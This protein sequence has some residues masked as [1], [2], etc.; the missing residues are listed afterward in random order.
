MKVRDISEFL[1]YFE[2][3]ADSDSH[4]NKFGLKNGW[5]SGQIFFGMLSSL[6]DALGPK[7][8]LIFH[9]FL[10]LGLLPEKFQ[11]YKSDLDLFCGGFVQKMNEVKRSQI[12]YHPVSHLPQSVPGWVD[13]RGDITMLCAAIQ[14][15]S[16]ISFVKSKFLPHSLK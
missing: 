15:A 11:K 4:L 14:H 12:S 1:E 6:S 5:V 10:P 13:D 9:G 16:I 7:T 2:G 3:L 8:H